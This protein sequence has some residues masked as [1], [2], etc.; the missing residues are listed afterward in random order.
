MIETI[1]VEAGGYLLGLHV[2]ATTPSR[3]HRCDDGGGEY[4]PALTRAVANVVAD[5]GSFLDVGSRYGYYSA[6]AS[7][8]GAD[9]VFA[10]D[11]I[12]ARVELTK[13]NVP[14]A[15]V[16]LADFTAE[17]F[18]WRADV[19]KV[20]IEG[21]EAEAVDNLIGTPLV[22]MEVHPAMLGSAG[23]ESIAERFE[24]EGYAVDYV[25]HRRRRAEWSP[26]PPD[27]PDYV[28]RAVNHD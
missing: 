8:A 16:F 12:P 1:V 9:S 23:V 4:E 10:F 17:S 21:A 19:A 27:Q 7:A 13:E 3:L 14:S 2:D 5:G 24:A 28:L 18:E 26:E 20:D 6:L 25:D 15:T 11:V 22:F